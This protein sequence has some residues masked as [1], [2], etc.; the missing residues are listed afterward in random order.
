MKKIKEKISKKIISFLVINITSFY[1]IIFILLSLKNNLFNLLKLDLFISSFMI[2]FRSYFLNNLFIFI[3]N[4]A[5]RISVIL[6]SI[7]IFT[8]LYKKKDKFDSYFYLINIIVGLILVE[9]LKNIIKR[10]RPE[11]QLVD[12]L[13]YSFPSGHTTFATIIA[14]SIY[15]IY[16]DL[17]KEKL[18]S[19]YLMIIFIYPILIGFSRIFL[20]V[21]W[22]TDVI[23]GFSLGIF[24]VTF[25]YLI[26]NIF[27]ENKKIKK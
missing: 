7:I 14:L 13:N 17:F 24:I 5:D 21:H 1:L 27:F 4:L 9:S 19:K 22:L 25:T 26:M 18:K 2:N 3:T 6:I 12:M 15:F 10:L 11:N 23:A 16:K 8:Y 20:N